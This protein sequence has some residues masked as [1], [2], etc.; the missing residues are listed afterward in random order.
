[1][2]VQRACALSVDAWQRAIAIDVLG[3]CSAEVSADGQAKLPDVHVFSNEI[4]PLPHVHLFSKRR[5]MQLQRFR[6]VKQTCRF[7]ASVLMDEEEDSQVNAVDVDDDCTNPNLD[8]VP[9]TSSIVL[10]TALAVCTQAA[11]NNGLLPRGISKDVF[12]LLS[13]KGLV[14][15]HESGDAVLTHECLEFGW[16]CQDAA[17]EC[18]FRKDQSLLELEHSLKANGWESVERNSDAS[19]A[20]KRMVGGNQRTYYTLLI[21]CSSGL[22]GFQAFQQ[23]SVLFVWSSTVYNQFLSEY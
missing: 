4:Q 7:N 23:L 18:T 22:A 19:I 8:L 21:N 2:Y 9:P 13:S 15:L 11:A 10:D 17:L 16:F 3:H 5:W 14:Q 20:G 6:S 12:N 1:M